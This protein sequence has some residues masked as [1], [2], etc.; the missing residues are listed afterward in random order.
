MKCIYVRTNLVNGKKYVGQAN[1]FDKR[2]QDWKYDSRYSGGVIDKARNK[3]GIENFETKVLRECET[4][5]ELNYWEQ[6]Y[7]K[8]LNTK[9]PNGY[10]L[11]DGGEGAVGI[12]VS[13]ET[14]KKSSISHKGQH[15]SPQTEIK[16][17]HTP[18]NKGK[19]AYQYTI[20]GDFVKEWDFIAECDKK[21]F[22][23]SKVILCCQGKRKTHK[24]FIWSYTKK[25]D[26]N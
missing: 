15:S 7:I 13:A 26:I 20:N 11:T 24:G 6:Y 16:K 21:G 2:E 10:N 25:E 12:I 3:Y 8:E 14:R 4:K 18:W 22:H 5:E 19:K 17:G 1:N 23:H 9:V